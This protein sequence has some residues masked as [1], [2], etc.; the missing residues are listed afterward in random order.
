MV[1]HDISY[2]AMTCYAMICDGMSCHAMIW[3]V[4]TIQNV[5]CDGIA[6]VQHHMI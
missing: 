2:T 1:T 4:V 6:Y 3:D 5:R